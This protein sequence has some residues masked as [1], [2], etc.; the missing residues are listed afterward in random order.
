MAVI[1]VK[2]YADGHYEQVDYFVQGDLSGGIGVMPVGQ[3]AFDGFGVPR[4]RCNTVLKTAQSTATASGASLT[5]WTPTSTWR[6]RL[7]G[8][9]ARASNAG[10]YELRDGATIIA[11]TYLPANTWVDIV[12][13]PPNGYV[14]L[15]DD[16]LLTIR[17]NSGAAADIDIVAWG[18]E[19]AFL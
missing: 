5:V 3:M 8:A 1:Y 15:A 18:T 4:L 14:S 19:E 12:D 13:M 7:F 17:N 6:F 16:N 9:R 2:H 11:Y 10:R